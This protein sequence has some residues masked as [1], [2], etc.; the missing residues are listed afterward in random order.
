MRGSL[1]M[2]LIRMLCLVLVCG[3]IVSKGQETKE[4]PAKQRA[5]VVPRDI[6]LVSIASQPDSPLQIESP[7]F[8]AYLRGG[9]GEVFRLRNRGNKPIRKYTVA[10]ISANDTGWQ[11]DWPTSASTSVLM[12]GDFYPS[13]V[14]TERFEIVP[15]TESLR[16][17]LHLDGRMFGMSVV[18]IV[19]VEFSDGTS[20][21]DAT[22]FKALQAY[23]KDLA[24]KVDR[25]PR[26]RSLQ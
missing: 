14:E 4:S 13:N 24:L 20:Y 3:A 22:T 18:M 1:A 25:V 10:V 17:Q 23:F 11:S 26:V 8:L 21:D 5:V 16:K 9:G 2:R 7:V 12:P 15:L 19:R 6:V